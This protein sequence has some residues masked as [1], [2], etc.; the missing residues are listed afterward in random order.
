MIYDYVGCAQLLVLSFVFDLH[1]T[2]SIWWNCLPWE[3]YSYKSH[4]INKYQYLYQVYQ[5]PWEPYS[6]QSHWCKTRHA[7]NIPPGVV[8]KDLGSGKDIN[9]MLYPVN[10]YI[11]IW[12]HFL[13]NGWIFGCLV[14]EGVCVLNLIEFVEL[15]HSLHCRV[16]PATISFRKTPTWFL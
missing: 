12:N 3:P 14:R 6:Y 13:L 2:Q 7:G 16:I 1:I 15:S 8:S 4:P 11:Y 10:E 9:A 5:L